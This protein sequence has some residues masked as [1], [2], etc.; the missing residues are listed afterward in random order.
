[1]RR[2]L[3]MTSGLVVVL[4]AGGFLFGDD[5]KTPVRARGTLPPNWSKL[6]L[7]DEQKQKVYSIQG[8]YRTKIDALNAQIKA[9]RK[10]EGSEMA[11]ILTDA[12]R[13]RLREIVDAK[14]GT[15]DSSKESRKTGDAG[16]K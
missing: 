16:K 12:Q 10:Q 2:Q 9:L 4:L 13:A 14:A 8:E 11:K 7:T 5:E 1:M 15:G 3:V 6:G